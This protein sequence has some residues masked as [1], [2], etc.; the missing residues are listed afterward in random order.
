MLR[1][2]VLTW[3]RVWAKVFPVCVRVRPPGWSHLN[4]RAG[5]ITFV[6]APHSARPHARV[7]G[8]EVY[9]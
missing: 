4:V 7:V 6:P 9:L 3:T 8:L 2:R 1:A 5:A